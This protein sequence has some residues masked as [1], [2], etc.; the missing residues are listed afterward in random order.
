MQNID[1]NKR[2]DKMYKEKMEIESIRDQMHIQIMDLSSN[3]EVSHTL[4]A[5]LSFFFFFLRWSKERIRHS[6]IH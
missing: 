5:L 6:L 1:I 2:S 3:C 4:L